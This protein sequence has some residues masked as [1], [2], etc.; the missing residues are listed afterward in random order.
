MGGILNVIL[1]RGSFLDI[2]VCILSSAIVVFLTLP[3]HEYAHGFAATKLGDPTPR[4]QGR[5]TLNPLAHL[6][7]M[8]S[9]MIFLIGFGW[10]RP[11][12][13]NSRY[14]KREKVDMAITALAGP[15]SNIIVAFASMIVYS[16]IWFFVYISGG[17]ASVIVLV[18]A[19]IF[20]Y[21]AIINI[22]LAVFNLVP[23]PPLD[24]SKILA[25][26]LPN[27]IYYKLMQYERY[28]SLIIMLLI[29]AGSTFSN[30]LS[31]LT[32]SIYTLLDTVAWFPFELIISAMNGGI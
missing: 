31:S 26:V 12:M 3:I 10:A 13:V 23:I 32:Y 19:Q 27:R 8:G 24:G 21:I 30:V 18:L 6:D 17:S 4:Y 28:F 1:Q 15:L 22:S 25:V 20:Q 9:V 2:L 11:V 7:Y 16:I 14:F 29:V 5:M